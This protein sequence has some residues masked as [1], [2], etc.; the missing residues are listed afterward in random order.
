MQSL[1]DCDIDIILKPRLGDIVEQDDMLL[2]GKSKRM[3]V[4]LRTYFSQERF[5]ASIGIRL[6]CV[7]QV[8]TAIY[9]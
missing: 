4:F 3:R 2:Y 7:H 5:Y 8:F 9:F 1:L 6:A